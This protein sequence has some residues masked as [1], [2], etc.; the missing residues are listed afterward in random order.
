MFRVMVKVYFNTINGLDYDYGEYSGCYHE[1][2]EEA[3]I[4]LEEAKKYC[5]KSLDLV[6]EPFIEEF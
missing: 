6:G 2:I 1:T 4:E 5:S 3:E